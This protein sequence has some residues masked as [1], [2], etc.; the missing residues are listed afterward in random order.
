MAL[1]LCGHVALWLCSDVAMWLHGDVAKWLCGQVAMWLNGP[2]PLNIPTPPPQHSDSH[3]Y[4]KPTKISNFYDRLLNEC[5]GE[6]EDARNPCGLACV[7]AAEVQ[8]QG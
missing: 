8:A 2:L 5:L 6:R 3:L 1:S 7:G 4:G